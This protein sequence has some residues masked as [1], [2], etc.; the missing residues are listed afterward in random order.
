[1]DSERVSTA[2]SYE[3]S[4]KRKKKQQQQQEQQQQQQQQQQKSRSIQQLLV[5]ISRSDKRSL[6][7]ENSKVH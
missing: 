1:M 4:C 3:K 7:S 5:K 2:E 6:G